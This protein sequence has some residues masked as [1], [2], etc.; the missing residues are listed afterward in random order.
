[1]IKDF[2]KSALDGVNIE[3]IYQLAL[4]NPTRVHLVTESMT[5]TKLDLDNLFKGEIPEEI[6]SKIIE[7]ETA[8]KKALNE[9]N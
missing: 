7:I 5:Q 1:M 8:L 2:I 3:E 4:D 6:T 9:I